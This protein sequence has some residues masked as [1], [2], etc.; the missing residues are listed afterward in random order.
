MRLWSARKAAP[1]QT[2]NARPPTLRPQ[3]HTVIPQILRWVYP[4]DCG[5]QPEFVV[6]ANNAFGQNRGFSKPLAE[7][8]IDI[9]FMG[10][11]PQALVCK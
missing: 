5:G 11:A 1:Q 3:V 8:S 9:A 10:A 7:R 6:M 4:L 2:L